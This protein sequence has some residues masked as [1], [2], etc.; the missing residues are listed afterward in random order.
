MPE[1]EGSETR[2]SWKTRIIQKA[3]GPDS[4]LIPT[5]ERGVDLFNRVA[6]RMLKFQHSRLKK[7]LAQFSL[8]QGIQLDLQ[9]HS[10]DALTGK[11]KVGE[12]SLGQMIERTNSASTVVVLCGGIYMAYDAAQYLPPGLGATGYFKNLLRGLKEK[13]DL[14]DTSMVICRHATPE[15][16]VVA[17]QS[18]ASAVVFAG[19][20]NWGAWVG[21]GRQVLREEQIRDL[22]LPKDKIII[23]NTC[24][25][26]EN[27]R[28]ED[29]LGTSAA[30]IVYGWNRGTDPMQML[31]EP[32]HFTTR[33]EFDSGSTTRQ[34]LQY[35]KKSE[36]V[37]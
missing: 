7:Q 13:H 5:G 35:A 21:A 20:G 9:F 10:N 17:L 26:T 18:K 37:E 8:E 12:R 3:V 19:H 15:D 31:K 22:H 14:K 28:Y 30:S 36:H 24:G 2:T 11:A 33:E 4:P 1:G 29:Q 6:D 16:A 32:M 23:R 27:Q 34:L 25:D